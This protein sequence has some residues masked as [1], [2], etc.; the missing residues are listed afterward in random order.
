LLKISVALYFYIQHPL[1]RS[2][3]AV[4]E[5]SHYTEQQQKEGCRLPDL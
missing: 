1:I 3:P 2:F 4:C 5:L